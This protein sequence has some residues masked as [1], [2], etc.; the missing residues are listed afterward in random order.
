[1]EEAIN[2]A[3][4]MQLRTSRLAS[5]TWSFWSPCFSAYF[6]PMSSLSVV[7]K[8]EKVCLT[9][10]KPSVNPSMPNL[11]CPIFEPEPS[12]ASARVWCFG[13]T[14]WVIQDLGTVTRPWG[15]SLVFDFIF[16]IFLF[17]CFFWPHL[18][19]LRAYF[20]LCIQELF[21]YMGFLGLNLG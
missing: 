8:H 3:I 9:L 7:Y 16:L 10:V 5:W 20:W 6:S 1:M 2:W 19:V 15:L 4:N 11:K 14:S 12:S 21:L 13:Q 17:I 18:A